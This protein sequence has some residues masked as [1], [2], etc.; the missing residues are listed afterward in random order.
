MHNNREKSL[1][2]PLFISSILIIVGLAA[3]FQIDIWHYFWPIIAVLLGVFIIF[4]TLFGRD[5]QNMQ[6][7][8]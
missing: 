8:K 7:S 4:N 5:K 1:I 6:Y 2:W 3:L